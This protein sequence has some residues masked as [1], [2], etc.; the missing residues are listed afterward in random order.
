MP[1]VQ[2]KPVES[3]RPAMSASAGR[4][5]EEARDPL[6]R[7]KKMSTTAGIGYGQEY[8]A[9][10]P[11]AV[12]A[13]LLGLASPLVF[14]HDVLLLV[15]LAGVVCAA[16]AW[17]QIR[18]SNGTQTGRIM[19]LAGLVLCLAI[20]GGRLAW[21]VIGGWANRADKAQ[22]EKLISQLGE[23]L[24]HEEYQAAYNMFTP[25]FQQRV[26]L[27]RFTDTYQQANAHPDGGG[28]KG[29]EWNG[30]V[31][32]EEEAESKA[33]IAYAMAFFSFRKAEEPG[34]IMVVLRKDG[35]RW[36]LDDVPAMFPRDKKAAGA[37]GGGA[38]GGG[39]GTR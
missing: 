38:S 32:F 17:Q 20:G 33:R 26:G 19:A 23:H 7:L 13:L 11:A 22:I 39:A 34:R 31:E 25:P 37:A 12:A 5:G 9:V 4:P 35:G 24:S 28:I 2:E 3:T 29:M 18:N 30:R 15:P 10:N 27:Q 6:A 14:V 21:N 8:V 16:I 36:Q 1:E